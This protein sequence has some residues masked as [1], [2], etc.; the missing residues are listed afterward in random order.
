MCR[1][2]RPGGRTPLAGAPRLTVL[3]DTGAI[4]ALID[5]SDSWHERV[6][7]WWAGGPRRVRLPVTII[8]EISNLLGTR[9]GPEAEEAFIRALAGGEFSIEP[10]HDEDV[11]RAAELMGTY[12]DAPL[13]F[14]DAS[15]VAQ[16]ERLG[17]VSVLTTDR[18]YFSLVRPR[19]V[20]SFR[21]S[22]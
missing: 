12:R 6:V 2:R 7:T 18:R 11:V 14:V 22:P 16:A 13:G 20:S 3:A 21:L 10:L 15:I 8:P 9:L 1:H 17:V 4:Y 19:H 5:R